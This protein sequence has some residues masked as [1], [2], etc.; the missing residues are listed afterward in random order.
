M[1]INA[2]V[3]VIC[4]N[5]ETHIQR[6]LE[7]V[8]DFAEVI[9][10]DSGSTDQTL[11]ISAGYPNVIIYH[12]QWLGY[13]GQKAFAL[14]K[15]SHDWVI[16]LDADEILSEDLKNQVIS[17]ITLN[18]CDAILCRL[19]EVFLNNAAHKLSKHADK[20]RI[21]KRK[22]GNYNLSVSVHESISIAGK[23]KPVSGVI[24]HYGLTSIE[25]MISKNNTY[26]T[27][28]VSDKFN[29]GK[30]ACLAKL[31]F[32]FFW[33]FFR[34]YFFKRLFL[35]G[36]SGFIHSMS[37]GFYAFLKEAKLYELE[38]DELSSSP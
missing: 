7:N 25:T 27:L 3:Y 23:I 34:A 15:C 19:S 10:V 29:K 8:R 28:A 11:A 38:I 24:Y 31:I 33:A 12:Q 1:I 30:R 2:S 22:C 6:L 26:S 36:R 21:F 14:N 35:N 13:A 18:E 9:L 20:I 37:I 32:S 4:C 5:E 16:N 17:T